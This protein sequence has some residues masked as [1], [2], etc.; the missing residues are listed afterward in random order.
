M[1]D[2][3]YAELSAGL[4]LHWQNEEGNFW[5][6]SG[7]GLHQ[8]NQPEQNFLKQPIA[9][10]PMRTSIYAFAGGS[11]EQWEWLGHAM[12]QFQGKGKQSNE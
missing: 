1:A 4:N 7:F 6:N 9:K 3:S 2:N 10:L 11:V 5:I 12:L 8:I